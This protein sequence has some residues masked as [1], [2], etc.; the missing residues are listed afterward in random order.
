MKL[1]YTMMHGQKN[2]KKSTYST[3]PTSVCDS[4]QNNV[5]KKKKFVTAHATKKNGGFRYY[6]QISGEND[7]FIY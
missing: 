4:F 6:K 2:I 3:F 1:F 5:K 7:Y